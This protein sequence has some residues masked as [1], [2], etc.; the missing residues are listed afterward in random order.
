MPSKLFLLLCLALA[1]LPAR[2]LPEWTPAPGTPQ[3]STLPA[4]LQALAELPPGSVL[5]LQRGA[6]KHAG[7]W[8]IALPDGR[9]HAV[10]DARET[11]HPD[12]DITVSGTLAGAGALA[13]V[14]FT[15]GAQAGFGLVRAPQGEFRFERWGDR[16]WLIDTDAAG[17]EHADNDDDA[18]ALSQAASRARV[19]TADAAKAAATSLDVLFVYTEGFAARYPGSAAATRLNHLVA[20]ANQVFANSHADL[21]LRAV[22]MDRIGYTDR[23]DNGLA[24]EHLRDAGAG[25]GVVGMETV[26]ARR[27]ATGADLVTLIRPHDVEI[28]GSCG[29]AFL[30]TGQ[31]SEGFNVLSDG[32][33]SWSLCDDQVFAHEVG[34]N[35]GAEHQNGANSPNAGFG[36]AFIVPGRF[37]TVMSSFGSGTPDRRLGLL[38][39]SNP[40]LRCGG[41]ACGVPNV[42]DNARRL[43]DTKAA[44]AAF[45]AATV[46]GEAIAPAPLDPDSDGDGARDSEDAFPF[47]AGAQRDGDGDGVADNRD[48]FPTN[49]AESSDLDGDGIGDNADPDRDGDGVANAQDALPDDATGSTDADGDRVADAVDAFPANRGEAR[50]TDADG[51]GDNADP[52]SDGDGIADVADA[53][54]LADVD[55][56]VAS[57]DRV[58]RLDGGSGL[59]GGVEIVETH[60]PQALGPRAGL[61]WDASRKR[62]DALVAGDVRRYERAGRTREAILV[63][64]YRGGPLPGLPSGLASGFAVGDDGMVYVGDSSILTLHRF[65]A[66]TGVERPGGVFG[67]TPLFDDVPRALA[68]A[69]DGHLWALSRD[70][71]LREID[72]ATGALLATVQPRQAGGLITNPSAMVVAPD[73][74]LLI[75]EQARDRIVRYVPGQLAVA[76]VFVAAGSGG[77]HGPAGLAFGPDGHLY[78]SSTGSDAILR[79]DG[80]TGAFIDVF[81]RTPPGAMPAP[82]AIAFAPKVLDRFPLDATRRYR[83]IAGGWSNVERAGHGIDLQTIGSDLAMTWYTYTTNGTPIWYLAVGPLRNGVFDAPLLQTAWDGTAATATPVGRARLVF[84]AENRATF[85]Y[86][87]GAV[88][89][90]EPM[91]PVAAGTSSETQF[92]TAAWF[93]PGQSGWGLT[94]AR[95]GEIAYAV[96]FVYD[97]DGVPTWAIGGGAGD[98]DPLQFSMTLPSGPCP[99]CDVV[100]VPP[101]PSLPAPITLGALAFDVDGTGEA[102]IDLALLHDTLDWHADALPMVRATDSP[103]APD[104][105][106]AGR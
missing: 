62:I 76:S 38:Q 71:R 53:Q 91:Q 89:G 7:Q 99:G 28:R 42:S 20:I 31:A 41:L 49:A 81:S 13:P 35:L 88:S 37:N 14:V 78:V 106:P 17:L 75:A 30:F 82:Q 1:S 59:Y 18:V 85:D 54:S 8:R 25:L 50:D 65:D 45:G 100:D 83:P 66:V 51:V 52:D 40:D 64:S 73:G 74:A 32:F 104:G 29:I 21:A 70:G 16:A 15:F 33:D 10:V 46:A 39:F 3:K 56:L 19:A 4:H 69:P 57:G 67:D 95:Q 63:E 97:L 92:P 9:M 2:A 72:A 93:A 90:S 87:V 98:A 60:V 96:A 55:L 36:T 102:T 80:V 94:V 77:L 34:H 27:A 11:L 48:A 101:P 23:N 58:L 86:T 68:V 84:A 79:Y 12:G 5:T 22:G 103:T 6:D 44:A 24:L 26:A 105:T 47:D 43:R 61:A